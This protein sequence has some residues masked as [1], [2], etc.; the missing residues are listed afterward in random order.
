[1]EI[2]KKWVRMLG[3][4][5]KRDLLD[6]SGATVALHD[7]NTLEGI[8]GFWD[9]VVGVFHKSFVKGG[10]SHGRSGFVLECENGHA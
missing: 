6:G 10:R 3:T 2:D 7:F 5:K 4:L 8:N 9:D 1:M